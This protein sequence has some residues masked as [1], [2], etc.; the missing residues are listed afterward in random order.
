MSKPAHVDS[1]YAATVADL[2]DY[3]ILEGAVE[4]DVCIVGAG[5]TGLSAALHLAERGYRVAVVEGARVGWGASGRNGGQ[6][7]TGFAA[8]LDKVIAM[9]GHDDARRLWALS[10]EAKRLIEDL[11]RPS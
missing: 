11:G 3:P 10:E 9:V 4:A 2:P 1:Y 6:I 5:F 7:V 8:G